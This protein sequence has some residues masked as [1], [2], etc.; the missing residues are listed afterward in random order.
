MGRID[1]TLDFEIANV[2]IS[3]HEVVGDIAYEENADKRKNLFDKYL[4][5]DRRLHLMMYALKDG[6]EKFSFERMH[7]ERKN[8]C[9]ADYWRFK[10]LW[11]LPMP[12]IFKR[13]EEKR[14]AEIEKRRKGGEHW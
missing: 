13:H 7:E 9:A 6:W 14:V 12:E 2:W 5:L 11:D 1:S 3:L 8:L 4:Y 10:E